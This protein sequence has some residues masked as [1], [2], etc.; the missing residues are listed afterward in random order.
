M[1]AVVR[2][3]VA[4]CAL[5]AAAGCK[6]Q[7]NDPFSED[8]AFLQALRAEGQ[9][10]WTP[11]AVV[12]LAGETVQREVV[13]V[14]ADALP[15]ELPGLS[16]EV[17]GANVSI[18]GSVELD[19][20]QL[21]PSDGCA[22]CLVAVV[23]M[24]G[25]VELVLSDETSESRHTTTWT[26]S[27]RGVAELAVADD[28]K[29]RRLVVRLAGAEDW[30]V[31]GSLK[32][33]PFGFNKAT[34]AFI[35]ERVRAIVDGGRIPPA[36]LVALPVQGPVG[37]HDV[38]ATAF[39]GGARLELRFESMPSRAPRVESNVATG[40]AGRSTDA[41]LLALSRIA[42]M[43][44]PPRNGRIAEPSSLIM[45]EEGFSVDVRLWPLRGRS[46]PILVRAWGEVSMEEGEIGFRATR[47]EVVEGRQ[48]KLEPLLLFEGRIL[49]GV[50]EA[51]QAALP[52]AHSF[53]VGRGTMRVAIER[54]EPR[55]GVIEI[56]GRLERIE[57]ESD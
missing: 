12:L 43:D 37:I 24:S 23:A 57:E 27:A 41:A 22:T 54:V 34:S 6:R 40:W 51:L 53:D 31:D 48:P 52:A 47:A 33:L 4:A 3:C 16:T 25:D 19:R 36:T 55:P 42:V 14:L 56:T 5:L 20:A 17:L 49:E 10:D 45:T 32:G 38:R 44:M 29:G 35:T 18:R 28:A 30:K 15:E 50:T 8:R 39:E 46:R 13:D 21:E 11:D 9:S 2:G 7:L 1:K 26:A